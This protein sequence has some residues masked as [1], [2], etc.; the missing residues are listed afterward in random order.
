MIKAKVYEYTSKDNGLVVGRMWRLERLD[1][2]PN[3]VQT[4]VFK[5]EEDS[6]R[7]AVSF[8]IDATSEDEEFAVIFANK[9]WDVV[10]FGLDYKPED[11]VS[12]CREYMT[13]MSI[14]FNQVEK[15]EYTFDTLS[16]ALTVIH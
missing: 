16:S 12:A 8:V 5:Y 15:Q 2:S 11:L 10:C 3:A 9:D 13:W 1:L 7:S 6:N 14:A 4:T